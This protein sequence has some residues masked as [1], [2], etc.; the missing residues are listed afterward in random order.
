MIRDDG[1]S[2]TQGKTNIKDL[3][4]RLAVK[5]SVAQ[6]LGERAPKHVYEYWLAKA[7]GFDLESYFVQ[8]PRTDED[9]WTTL[10]DGVR[11]LADRLEQPSWDL[12]KFN[13]RMKVACALH[14]TSADVSSVVTT[15]EETTDGYQLVETGGQVGV[16]ADYLDTLSF[17]PPGELMVARPVDFEARARILGCSWTAPGVLE[18]TCQVMV[19]GH[20]GN[21][22]DGGLTVDVEDADGNVVVSA[23]AERARV[24]NPNEIAADVYADHTH[25]VFR[26]SLDLSGLA[27][28]PH[29]DSDDRWRLLVRRNTDIGE[30]DTYITRRSLLSTAAA[31]PHGELVDGERLALRW[32]I[33]LGLSINRPQP[34]AIASRVAVTGRRISF[35]IDPGL[36]PH[37]GKP[38]REIS[39]SHK[40]SGVRIS[41]EP[42]VGEDGRKRFVLDVPELGSRYR[43]GAQRWKV[44]VAYAD[45]ASELLQFGGDDAQL[46]QEAHQGNRLAPALTANGF[47]QFEDS[48]LGGC[49]SDVLVNHEDSAVHVSGELDF[50]PA[51]GDAEVALVS[52]RG[53]ILRATDLRIEGCRFSAQ[54]PL[55]LPG[56]EMT[57]TGGYSLRARTVTTTDDVREENPWRW[58]PVAPSLTQQLPHY[59]Q[60]QF[61]DLRFSRTE[62]ARSLWVNVY[63]HLGEVERGRFGGRK[64]QHQLE[65]NSPELRDAI[66]FE[67]YGGKTCTDSPAAI[68]AELRRRG[69][70]RPQYFGISDGS[71]IA[72]E[73]TTPVVIGS[74][75][76]RTL[77]STCRWLVNNNN[78]P[79]YFRKREGQTYVQTWHGTPLKRIGNDVPGANL[80]LSYRGLMQRE[81]GYWDALLSQNEYSTSIFP[82]AFGYHGVVETLGYP[83]NDSLFADDAGQHR[84]SVR[85]ELGVPGDAIAVLYAP[86]W[87]DNVKTNGG[88]YKLVTYLDV[89]ELERVL[90]KNFVVLQRGHSNT[91]STV[92]VQD[93][94]RIIDVTSHPD[95]NGLFLASDALV[96]DY[97]SVFFDYSD[98]GKPILFLVPDLADYAGTTRGFYVDLHEIAPG[99]L[100]M[101]SAEV[102]S[103]LADE[104]K[105]HRE[106][107]DK[108]KAFTERFT[109]HD[110]GRTAA[111]VVDHLL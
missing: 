51:E 52:Q 29:G 73:G 11:R 109:S 99:P 45:G 74:A 98:T 84:A 20:A 88:A 76:Y 107:N 86:T 54:I 65:H 28:L 96:T 93:D 26:V 50:D 68:A 85:A 63:P 89:D 40:W 70:E 16:I 1:T 106:W 19:V 92:R 90:G 101:D 91:A 31:F 10:R 67:S 69:D 80:S 64:F 53:A 47:L 78:F 8:I 7:I 95:L 24:T 72:P 17:A 34:H 57:Q 35:D 104:S 97:S 94:P 39:L 32:D 102:A 79:Y 37:T 4:D 75:E 22:D 103:W 71:V 6:I 5:R 111:V 42:R 60:L 3:E 44:R 82:G 33:G 36:S 21:P 30:F 9:Y 15:L 48:R 77:L 66:L 59:E 87:R 25:D 41:A 55:A 83:R 58:L 13:D 61:S 38:L 14:G 23:P 49:V 56:G 105:L 27:R 81:A 12:V 62:K 108:Y 18:L 100:C 43:K 46:Y 110:S 2:I